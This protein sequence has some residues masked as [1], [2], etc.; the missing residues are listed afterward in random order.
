VQWQDLILQVLDLRVLLPEFKLV[1][2]PKLIVLN[3]EYYNPGIKSKDILLKMAI[4]ALM[5]E[6]VSTSE[7][8]VNIYQTAGRNI[9]EDSHL[10][11]R[12]RENLKSHQVVLLR[13]RQ[14]VKTYKGRRSKVIKFFYNSRQLQAVDVLTRDRIPEPHAST[15]SPCPAFQI[16]RIQSTDKLSVTSVSL[17]P[18]PLCNR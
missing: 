4:I 1:A 14:A 10:H 11:T 13:T 16:V 6:A 7:T 5:M 2:A 12:R 8:S 17:T 15:G 9:P 18:R 3:D